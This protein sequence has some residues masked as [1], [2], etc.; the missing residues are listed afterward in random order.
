[1]LACNSVDVVDKNKWYLNM[2]YSNHIFGKKELFIELD[3]S[4]CGEIK[5]GNNTVLPV[6]GKKKKSLSD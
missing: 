3:E 6:I 2:V 5:F 4:V 1:M